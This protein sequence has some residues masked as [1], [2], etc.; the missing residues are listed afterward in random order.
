MDQE[1]SSLCLPLPVCPAWHYG[2]APGS[3]QLPTIKAAE[4]AVIKLYPKES[5]AFINMPRDKELKGST[6]WK[7]H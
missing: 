7:A 5:R 6:P 2:E 1:L 3:L 4:E